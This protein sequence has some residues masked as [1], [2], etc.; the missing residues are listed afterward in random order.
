M[1][2]SRKIEK[3]LK[4]YTNNVELEIPVDK[5]FGDY[6]FPCFS[7]TKKFKKNPHKIALELRDKIILPKDFD[8]I[9]VVGP[10]LNFF[11]NREVFVNKV[12]GEILK[13]K[14]KYGSKNIRKKFV[15]EYSSPNIAK[16]FGIGHLRST[17]IGN[18]LYNIHKFLGYNCVGIN[19]MGDWGKQFGELI[20]GYKRWGNKNM[21]KKD[22]INHLL[23]VYVMFH[24]EVLKNKKLDDEANDWFL[25]LEKGDE[26]ALGLWKEFRGYS[27]LEFSKV[28]GFLGIRFDSYEGEAFYNNKMEKDINF[29]KKKKLTEI[30]EGALIIP[31]KK[32]GMPPC[33]LKKG[34]GSSLYITRDI[35]AAIYRYKKYKFDKLVY[36]VGSEQLL[37]FKQLFKVLELAEFKWAKNCFH[38][39]HGLYL[40]ND[41]KKFGTRKGKIVLV[42]A[43]LNERIFKVRKIISEKNPN[44]KDI[45]EVSKL[46]GVGAIIYADLVTD[47]LRDVIFDWER[48]LD[49]DG[50]SGP[51]L[52]YAYVRSCSIL[53]KASRFKANVLVVSDDSEVELVKQLSLF[54]QV[55]LDVAN[56]YKPHLLAN[57]THLLAQKFNNFY[58][59]CDVLGS[60]KNVRDS[61]LSLCLAF[62]YVLGIS[63][64][65]LGIGILEEM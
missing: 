13:K 2:F 39:N 22:P 32:Y 31:L 11:V 55:V 40:D 15:I 21:L 41:G 35:S 29:L 61:R 54:S 57:Y 46:A 12:V 25:R 53:N 64:G 7:L 9:E 37:H 17:V 44:L 42:E 33:L 18:C 56:H 30:N 16:P 43:L 47:R 50:K 8:K 62:K 28:Y 34:D 14:K 58:N 36:E 19:H 49:F 60:N 27:L 10:Y 59:N 3:I 1:Y 5:K 26:E 20:V 63:L 52:Q 6:A 4:K 23:E 45:G 48:V 65:L 38:V 51:Y 24:K